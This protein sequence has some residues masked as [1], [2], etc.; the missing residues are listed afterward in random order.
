MKIKISGSQR[1]INQVGFQRSQNHVKFCPSVWLIHSRWSF[2]PKT[3]LSCP[4]FSYLLCVCW[5][6]LNSNV[7]AHLCM[8]GM[9]SEIKLVLVFLIS[10]IEEDYSKWKHFLVAIYILE[11]LT[12]TSINQP[13]M[14]ESES[15]WWSWW[16]T[17]QICFS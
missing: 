10:F 2:K 3:H 16:L 5:W 11:L 8:H 1:Y 9:I 6:V 17:N 12:S 13:C 14:Y 7:C 15:Y 4:L